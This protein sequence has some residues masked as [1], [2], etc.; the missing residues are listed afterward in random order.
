MSLAYL[1]S[2][3]KESRLINPSRVSAVP[4]RQKPPTFQGTSLRRRICW[5]SNEIL[6][7]Y[8]MSCPVGLWQKAKHFG[9]NSVYRNLE[10]RI[11]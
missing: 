2:F 6:V 11:K 5:T 9:Q 3:R 10:P 4:V 8:P 7:A 1:F